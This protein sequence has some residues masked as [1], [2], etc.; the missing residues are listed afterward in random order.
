VPVALARYGTSALATGLVITALPV[1]FAVAATTADRVLPWTWSDATRSRAGIL[2][3]LGALTL[4]ALLPARA[5]LLPYPLALL[6]LA[7]G[8]FIPANNTLVMRAIPAT[9]AGTGGG[10]VNMT[11]G[12]GTAIG[13]AAVTLALHLAAPAN[14]WLAATGV[15]L[16]FGALALATTFRRR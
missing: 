9:S 6:G 13:V 16:G 15:L 14:G 7:L 11:R 10:M 4:L 8:V 5:G 1:G 2:G 12:L 3:C